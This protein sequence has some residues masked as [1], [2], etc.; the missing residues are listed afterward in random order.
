MNVCFIVPARDE[1]RFIADCLLSIKQQTTSG[2]PDTNYMITVV[3]NE[4]KDGTADISSKL[5]AKVI[6]QPYANAGTTRNTGANLATSDFLAFVDADCT[7]PANWLERCLSH[8]EN[9]SVVAVGASQAYSGRTSPWIERIWTDI[10]S[11]RA[12]QPWQNADWLPAFN[13]MVKADIFRRENGF[14]ESLET[15]EDSDL[16]LRLA[17]HGELRLDHSIQVRHLGE[18]RRPSEFFRREMWRSKGNFRSALKRRNLIQEFKS[19]VVPT[20]YSLLVMIAIL[21]PLITAFSVKLAVASFLIT[22][23]ITIGLPLVIAAG[24]GHHEKLIAKS[25]AIAI[26]LIARGIGP[27]V[28]TS[29]VSR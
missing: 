22:T 4:S 19:I 2:K 20:A 10:I 26:Y 15:C 25:I 14:D 13:L 3:D 17:N 29:R 28:S 18:S 1:E 12:T 11:P 5:G 27:F 24:K 6:H 16:T 8:F 21:S 23:A 7:L 9:E